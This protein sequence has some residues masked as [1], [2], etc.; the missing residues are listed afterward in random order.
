MGGGGEWKRRMLHFEACW[1]SRI[2]KGGLGRRGGAKE[3]H[4]TS[5]LAGRLSVCLLHPPPSDEA[6]VRSGHIWHPTAAS[7]P[8]PPFG[9]RSKQCVPTGVPPPHHEIKQNNRLRNSLLSKK[10][11][12]LGTQSINMQ[13]Q[14]FGVETTPLLPSCLC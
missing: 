3:S 7:S 9:Q 6:A 12:P 5:T 8:L 1:V 4:Q 2:Q 14:F 11:Q 10:T 13:T